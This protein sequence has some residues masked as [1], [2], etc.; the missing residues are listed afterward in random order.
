L[1]I[2]YWDEDEENHTALDNLFYDAE[3]ELDKIKI[4]HFPL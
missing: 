1:Y 3:E 4:E 2:N